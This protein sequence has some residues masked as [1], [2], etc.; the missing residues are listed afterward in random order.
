MGSRKS[1]R[2]APAAED[3]GKWTL[4]VRRLTLAAMGWLA[5][6]S[7]MGYAGTLPMPV[8]IPV[9]DDG[10]LPLASARY[11]HGAEY[12]DLDAAHYIEQEFLLSG[13]ADAISAQGAVVAA[14]QPYVTRILVRR[15]RD[16]RRFSGTVV[17]EPFSFAG[18]RAGG[19]TKI[20]AHLLR[21]GDA[22][23]G[24]T[25]LAGDTPSHGFAGPQGLMQLKTYDPARYG[26]LTLYEGAPGQFMRASSFSHGALQPDSF[27]PQG[28][29]ILG[30]MAELLKSN[31]PDGPL[32]GLTARRLYTLTWQVQSQL[33]I[34]WLSQGRA[35]AWR[36]PDGRPLI[37]GYM[38]GNYSGN[39]PLP[40]QLP[41]DA[42]IVIV[43]SG[44]EI[45]NNALAGVVPPPDSDTPRLRVYDFNGS[46]HIG[47]RDVGSGSLQLAEQSHGAGPPQGPPP[48]PG[49]AAVCTTGL[50][51]DEP[52]EPVIAAIYAAMDGWVRTD[53]PMPRAPRTATTDG[54]TIKD[55]ATGMAE[56]GM[57][58]PWIAVPAAKYLVG[59][60]IGCGAIDVKLPYTA[61]ELRDRYGTYASY[62]AMYDEARER[63]A[64]Q[65][66]L[67]PEDR[68]AVR[69]GAS[70][71]D[72]K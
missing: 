13:R 58:P 10:R 59:D 66:F 32:A 61:A 37:D 2:P 33:W 19:W 27:A 17:I 56:G 40:P 22:W 38:L 35:A 3:V 44:R 18:E 48:R 72:F 25:L 34:D 6:V 11:R 4:R 54:K 65:G 57:R 45:A 68:D 28:Q 42:P 5:T 64:A 15:P 69:P 53:K 55:P 43:R 49:R 8:I 39:L 62:Q 41:G 12:A 14:G 29:M 46:A 7:T 26:A 36:M 23:I 30:E 20:A 70:P 52:V 21:H 31:R 71:D 63:F 50:S 9:Q 51:Y 60:E 47:T 1:L 24:I 67:L 16:A